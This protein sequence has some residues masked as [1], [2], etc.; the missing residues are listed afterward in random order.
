MKPLAILAVLAALAGCVD[1]GPNVTVPGRET[2]TYR[3]TRNNRV[4]YM[5]IACRPDYPGGTAKERADMSYAFFRSSRT[6]F[7]T[8][9]TD[10][11]LTQLR[12]PNPNI[13]GMATDIGRSAEAYAQRVA[14]RMEE[15][16]GCSPVKR[17]T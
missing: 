2:F 8:T 4:Y 1:T 17:P 6:E 5:V 14:A 7:S 10:E 11:L 3:E 16:Y 9:K 13:R 12:R 15:R